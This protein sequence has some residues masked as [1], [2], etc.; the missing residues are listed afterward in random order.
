MKS[1]HFTLL[2]IGILASFATLSGCKQ[3]PFKDIV[4][5]ER[6]ITDFVLPQNQIGVAEI[7][8]TADMGKVVVYVVPGTDLSKVA[9]RIET[10]YHAEVSPASGQPTDFSGTN[11]TRTYSVTSQSGETRSWTVEIKD[12]VSD[13]D[14]TWSMTN[15][16]FQYFIGEGESWGW[17]G[18]KALSS[19]IPDASKELDNTL[20]FAVTGVTPDGKLT[21]TFNHQPGP[22]GQFANFMYGTTDY[23]YK[24]RRLPRNQGTWLRNFADNTITFNPG[25]GQTKTV[26]L[27]FSADKRSLKLPFNVQPYDIDWSGSG[28][29]QELGGAKTYWYMLR[30]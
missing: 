30:K 17:N 19:N 23:N 25:T 7:T 22:D 20:T 3:D 8:R 16:Q 1:Q 6:A 12:Y 29:K 5:N 10:S 27:E 14:G 11:R 15:L 28:G 21:G 18:I 4:S 13:L 9:P 24:F 2:G 26:A